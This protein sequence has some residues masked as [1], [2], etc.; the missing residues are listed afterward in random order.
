VK[1]QLKYL[2]PELLKRIE[3]LKLRARY[4]MQGLVS[5]MH[6]SIFKGF[7]VEFAQHR[8][9][10]MGDDLRYLDWKVFGR[11]D[12]LYIKEFEQETNL[13]C[14]IVL[15][16]S[17]SMLYD[18]KNRTKLEFACFLLFALT[19]FILEQRDAIGFATFDTK[20]RLILPPSTSENQL[21][22]LN[23]ELESLVPKEKTSIKGVFESLAERIRKRSFVIIISDFLCDLT[24][25]KRGLEALL[26]N[27]NEVVLFH[28]MHRDE[29]S[30]DFNRTILFEGL[31]DLMRLK[32]DTNSIRRAYLEVVREYLSKMKA[33]ALQLRTDYAF[34]NTAADLGKDL[35]TYL[36]SRLSTRVYMRKYS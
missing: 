12:R 13:V 27:R 23:I 9:Y 28:V 18:M 1:K 2:N 36:V 29:L 32:I 6:R 33:L 10:C 5:G 31:E 30:F 21:V 7:S 11:T 20:S 3:S 14:Y 35:F 16:V 8:E 24:E 22:Y 19:Y 17:K 25:L 26:F 4:L 34:F 15:D